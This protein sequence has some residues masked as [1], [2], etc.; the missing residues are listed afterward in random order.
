YENA[1][2][3][4]PWNF[5]IWVQYGH[6]LK[7]SGDAAA[8]EEAYR[9]ALRLAPEVADT[10]LQ[11]GHVLKIQ[12]RTDEASAAYVDALTLEP[13]LHFASLPGPISRPPVCPIFID[14]GL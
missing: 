11:L 14:F 10:H 2:A 9:K 3:A 13:T 12:G 8:G 5:A 6:A 7:E 4:E 1:I